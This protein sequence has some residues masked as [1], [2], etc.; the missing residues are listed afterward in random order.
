MLHVCKLSH[1]VVSD[2]M[3]EDVKAACKGA[4]DPGNILFRSQRDRRWGISIR[5]LWAPRRQALPHLLLFPAAA[6]RLHFQITLNCRWA[7]LKRSSD[8]RAGQPSQAEPICVSKDVFVRRSRILRHLTGSLPRIHS[9]A[10]D[11]EP[12][13]I[14]HVFGHR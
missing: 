6:K 13:T 5:R 14:S 3:Q 8:H 11:L 7:L 10:L 9:R 2:I 4:A 12:R 1:A